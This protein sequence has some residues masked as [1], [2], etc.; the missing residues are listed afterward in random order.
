M[1]YPGQTFEWP[2]KEAIFKDTGQ[3]CW[4]IA[5]LDETDE[6]FSLFVTVIHNGCLQILNATRDLTIS[7]SQ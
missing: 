1:S 5:Y 3:L 2:H 6:D 4:I 7:E